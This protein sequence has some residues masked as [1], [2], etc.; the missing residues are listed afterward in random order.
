MHLLPFLANLNIGFR[1]TAAPNN[2]AA[3]FFFSTNCYAFHHI[4]PFF[5]G[6]LFFA[7]ASKKD[8]QGIG[9]GLHVMAKYV[10]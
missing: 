4:M 10:A 8:M 3:A 9:H 1:K 6:R 2:G 5:E 7:N